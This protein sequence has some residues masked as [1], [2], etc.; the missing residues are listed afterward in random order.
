MLGEVRSETL[1]SVTAMEATL[2]QIDHSLSLSGQSTDVLESIDRQ[3]NDSLTKVRGVAGAIDE[4]LRSIT[5]LVATMSDVSRMSERTIGALQTNEDAVA[6]LNSV[7][8]G[9]KQ[10]VKVFKVQ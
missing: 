8:A 9:L 1:A 4:Q 2:P 3:A 6:S 7:A 10:E 5:E